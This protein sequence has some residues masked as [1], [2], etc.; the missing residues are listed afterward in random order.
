MGEKKRLAAMTTTN[1]SDFLPALCGL[2]CDARGCG[3]CAT[4]LPDE[5]LSCGPISE[6]QVVQGQA[7]LRKRHEHVGHAQLDLFVGVGNLVAVAPACPSLL[8]KGFAL[9]DGESGEE[10][11]E[12]HDRKFTRG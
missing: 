5:P 12:A 9:G 3:F 1:L 6:R 11:F 4:T 2:G 10:G 8:G 7:A